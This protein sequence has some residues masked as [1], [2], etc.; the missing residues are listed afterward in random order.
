MGASNGTALMGYEAA[1]W[2][3]ASTCMIPLPNET[4]SE[5]EGAARKKECGRGS[6][7]RL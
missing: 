1:G 5:A 4:A 7:Y 3:S 2:W 6:S